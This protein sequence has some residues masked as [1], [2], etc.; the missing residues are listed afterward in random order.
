MKHSLYPVSPVRWRRQESK[1]NRSV[2]QWSIGLLPIWLLLQIHR[3]G[4]DLIRSP[5]TQPPSEVCLHGLTLLE[6][7]WR[8]IHASPLLLN[9]YS[10]T[11]NQI[12][13]CTSLFLTFL[14][15]CRVRERTKVS[16]LPSSGR[17]RDAL[18]STDLP[19]PQATA[20][21][22]WMLLHEVVEDAGGKLWY[23]CQLCSTLFLTFVS[24]DFAWV[25]SSRPDEWP[26][27]PQANSFTGTPSLLC[28]AMKL[29][30]QQLWADVWPRRAGRDD[31][32]RPPPIGGNLASLWKFSKFLILIS[33][34]M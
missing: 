6:L 18:P 25:S 3:E 1:F 8:H 28:T 29:T 21:A 32:G 10:I 9:S 23:S 19:R 4:P 20:S 2:Q 5:M 16:I 12:V 14:L 24:N 30:R 27:V 34:H 33:K 15:L 7:Q 17:E 22:D 11:N 13:F 31:D 26:I